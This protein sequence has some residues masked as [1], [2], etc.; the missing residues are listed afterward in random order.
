[1]TSSSSVIARRHR[2]GVYMYIRWTPST[3]TPRI[4]QLRGALPAEPMR[5]RQPGRAAGRARPPLPRLEP[6]QLGEARRA[7]LVE[8][9]D[10]FA[11]LVGGGMDGQ[12]VACVLHGLRPHEVAPPVELRLR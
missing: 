3:A 8:G 6:A 10:R 11:G 1:M 12:P 4:R 2:R 9:G 5:C 7:L